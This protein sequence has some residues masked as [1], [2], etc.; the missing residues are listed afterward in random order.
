[1]FEKSALIK[2]IFL[3]LRTY[4]SG[5]LMESARSNCKCVIPKSDSGRSGVAKLS[6]SNSKGSSPRIQ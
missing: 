2:G 5:M 3:K 4:L 1:M 6:S